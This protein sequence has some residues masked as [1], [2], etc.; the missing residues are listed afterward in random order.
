MPQGGKITLSTRAGEFPGTEF[1]SKFPSE[2]SIQASNNVAPGSV[3]RAV[4]LAVKD[5]GCGMDAET[6]ARLFEPF[7][8]TKKP[9]E[10]TGLGL[11]T[12]QRIV[13]ES[14]G[15]IEVESEPG[16]GTCI[17]VFLPA[18]EASIMGSSVMGS[19]VMGSS[20]TQS[21]I[22]VSANQASPPVET[23]RARELAF[24][25]SH[26]TILLV[27]DHA[28]ARKSMQRFLLDAGYRILAAHSGKEALKV[29]AEHSAEVDLLIADIMMPG[30]NGRELAET[31][32]GQKPG[33]RVL[34]ISGYEHAPVELAGGFAAGAV[35]L[36]RKPF[37]GKALIK[38]VVEVL[39][40]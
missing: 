17:E 8:T 31:L 4:S 9:G 19:S 29:F 7:F 39:Q 11:A 22:A 13:S 28:A 32:V 35:E 6:R 37:S 10:G 40:S 34:L 3:R 21:A 20:I 27:D 1:P 36:V 12:V 25:T 14:G 23:P 30:M 33:L 2:G 38:R 15:M 26:K 24:E 5:N 18:I 16:R